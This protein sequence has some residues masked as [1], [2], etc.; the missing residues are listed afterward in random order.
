MSIL[1]RHVS[2][3]VTSII[4]LIALIVFLPL[5]FLVIRET[6]TLVSRATGTPADIVVDAKMP[7]ETITT[8]FYHAFAQGGEESTDM[9][10]SIS[11]DV[12]AL[13]PKLIRLDHLYDLYHVVS[14]DGAGLHFDWS[15]L[16]TS[17]STILSTGAKPVL[18]LSYMPDVIAK[19]GIISGPPN[20]WNEW[21]FVVQQ[22]IEH[23]SGKSG[24]NIPGIYYE[25]WN[26]PN[27]PQ[28]GG[29]GL[30]GEKNY[31]TL[32]RYAAAGASN[33]KGVNT[34]YLG[35]P[36]TS[37]LFTAWITALADSGS[38]VN[39]FSWHSYLQDPNQFAV[40]QRNLV[41][42]LLPY[43][44][45]TLLPKLITEFGFTGDKNAAYGTSYVSAHA[46][47]TIRQ[48]I[49]GGPQY[50]FSFELKDGP[51]DT[52]GNGWG[53][54]THDSNGL[55]KKPRYYV[56]NF[57]D[58]MAGTRLTLSG[59]GSWVTAFASK[60]DNVIRILLV[61]FDA[62][63]AH[64][65]N[66]PVAVKGLEPG[67]YT[68]RQRLLLGRDTTTKFDVTDTMLSTDVYMNPQSVALLEISKSK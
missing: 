19:D 67:S 29:W 11:S 46:A 16:D 4:S 2:S 68:M 59:E 28:F 58:A 39:F 47:A 52:N 31:L 36:A 18:V 30:S 41:K 65:E 57:M 9:L 22:T 33:A 40:D 45:Y 5:F 50:L 7:L 66:V 15:K 48:L 26:E 54:I 20:D 6:V 63:G 25:V 17:V 10:A 49:S 21:A 62:N 32:Y 34:F 60:R 37:G 13:H 12:R 1:I 55:K 14:R 27:L 24:M 56:Y 38:R 23:Y 42:A 51:S 44:T 61:N 3:R 8:D 53:L 43:P 35:G 64:S